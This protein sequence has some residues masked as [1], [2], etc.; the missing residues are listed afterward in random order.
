MVRVAHYTNDPNRVNDD[1]TNSAYNQG[2]VGGEISVDV[3]VPYVLEYIK[4]NKKFVLSGCMLVYM[5]KTYTIA[6]STA[7]S[8][9]QTK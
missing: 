7:I 2:L 6:L 5:M 1:G 9:M 3:S 4:T 8:T